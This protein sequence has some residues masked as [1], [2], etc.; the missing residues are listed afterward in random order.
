M[1][2]T[3]ISPTILC[4]VKTNYMYG[5]TS[6]EYVLR[7]I[8][9]AS[10]GLHLSITVFFSPISMDCEVMKNDKPIILRQLVHLEI[11]WELQLYWRTEHFITEIYSSKCFVRQFLLQKC[12]NA[13]Q[14][15]RWRKQCW[16]KPITLTFQRAPKLKNR[17]R[18]VPR[19]MFVSFEF[20]KVMLHQNYLITTP[21]W[22]LKLQL[23]NWHIC[24]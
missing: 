20:F 15:T 21:F 18:N 19:L 7:N 10:R 24:S 23:T 22:E 2:N 6:L 5:R 13:K 17:L 3:H 11:W 16:Q 12:I 8:L 14:N 9:H 4:H 1:C